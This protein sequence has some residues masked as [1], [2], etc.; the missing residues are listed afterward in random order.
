[1]AQ[2]PP[3]RRRWFQFSLGTMFLVV[4]L[5]AVWLAQETQTVAERKRTRDWLF[6]RGGRENYRYDWWPIRRLLGD[7]PSNAI[8]PPSDTTPEE[9]ARLHDVFPEAY[10]FLIPREPYGEAFDR[11]RPETV[12]Q[13]RLG[14]PDP[15]TP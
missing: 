11:L 7:K 1:M 6:E 2:S 3:T 15:L 8:F 10:V 5:F 9:W 4:T 13:K 12:W 14:A